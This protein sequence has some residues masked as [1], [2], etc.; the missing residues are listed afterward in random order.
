MNRQSTTMPA[1]DWRGW[2]QGVPVVETGQRELRVIFTLWLVA[3]LLKHSGSAWDVAWHFRYV[4]GAL[5]PPHWLNVAGNLLAGGLFAFQMLTGK[6]VERT[7]FVA[8]Q[9]TF[10]IFLIHM[11]LDVL[12]HYLFGLDV[13]VWSPTH[14]LGFAATTAMLG[15]LLY[16]WLRL[17]APGHWRL[18]VALLCWA[19]LLD[20]AI[21]Q[22][23]QQEYGVIALDA[24]ARGITT[25][26]PELLVQ[27]GRSPEQFVRGGIP[28][29]L[30]PVW[31]VLTGALVMFSARRVLG[32]RWSATAVTLIY[33]AYRLIGRLL[34]GAFDFP[35][36][37]IP[38]M[39]LAGALVVDVAELFRW[40]PVV[41]ALA[42]MAGFYGSAVLIGRDTLM[43]AF[44]LATAPFVFV[45]LW[46]GLAAAQWWRDRRGHDMSVQ[47]A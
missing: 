44:P 20:D 12:N 13:T 43:P 27:A 14:V 46:G 23:G 3:F 19:F 25:A 26:S 7:G 1:R 11:P 47:A 37:F 35:V 29:W 4:F 16:S 33:L 24:Y 45:A 17:A 22:L 9:L 18:V 36:S 34:L 5:E 39:L 28:D 31:M 6:G 41:S 15:G 40:R 21:F 30:Y 42:L 10:M 8:M 38:A 2:M 32:W